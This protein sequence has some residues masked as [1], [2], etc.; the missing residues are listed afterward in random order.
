[1]AFPPFFGGVLR[2]LQQTLIAADTVRPLR[3]LLRH[4]NSR[5]WWKFLGCQSIT[6]AA[7]VSCAKMRTAFA[8][9]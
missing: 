2:N 8:L 5:H 4:W 3:L 6:F 9:V 7:R 1:M